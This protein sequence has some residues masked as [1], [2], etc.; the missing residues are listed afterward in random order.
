MYSIISCL[1]PYI[2]SQLTSILFTG[3]MCSKD[4]QLCTNDRVYGKLIKELEYLRKRGITIY[5]QGKKINVKFQLTLVF[6]DNLGLNDT[7]DM[8]TSFE[9]SCFCR[10]CKVCPEQWKYMTREDPSLFR[11][12][13]NYYQ[14]I[15][16]NSCKDTGIKKNSIFNTISGFH[17]IDNVSF[18]IMHDVLH[19][20]C[21]YVLRGV[22]FNL[23]FKKKYL[24]LDT[25][26]R[27]IQDFYFEK[28]TEINNP[29]K[30][31]YKK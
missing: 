24:T 4:K 3:L 11:T 12:R 16:F 25:L 8:T 28:N 17:V 27:K 22:I 29:P 2:A 26:N 7:F 1:P 5:V 14:D 31:Q 21:S 15:A 23:V 9:D 19:G 18:D 20:V 10:V 13:T 30:F 6:G